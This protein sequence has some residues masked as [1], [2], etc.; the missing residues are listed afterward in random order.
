MVRIIASVLFLCFAA[1]GQ[2]PKFSN[3]K[4]PRLPNGK[5]DLEA[6]TPKTADGKPDLSGVW[7]LQRSPG[8][9]PPAPPPNAAATT[10]GGGLGIPAPGTVNPFWN[11]GS[12]M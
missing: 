8:P 10:A 7:D 9:R 1:F 6:P 5:I 11:I 4:I 12:T 3:P 2:W